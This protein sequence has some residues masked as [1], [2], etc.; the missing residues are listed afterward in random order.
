LKTL[1]VN[2]FGGPGTGKSTNATLLFGKLKNAGVNAEYVPEF[3]KDLVWEGRDNALT[4]QPYITAKQM[5]RL[6]RLQGQVEVVVTD[7]PLLLGLIYQGEGCTA[8]YP[9][10][11]RESF[12]NFDNVNYFLRRDSDLHPYN[13]KGRMQTEEQAMDLDRRIYEML[14]Q[15]G[16]WFDEVPILPEEQTADLL[17]EMVQAELAMR[18]KT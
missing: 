11:V 18:G 5:F 8:S 1:V 6:Y 9:A 2:L 15:Q 12:D 3:A 17:R 4:F 10:F 14:Q 13:P 7:S 16:V